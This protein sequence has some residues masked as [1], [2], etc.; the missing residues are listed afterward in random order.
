[1]TLQLTPVSERTKNPILEQA[2]CE[3]DFFFWS[4]KDI[5]TYF[6]N[7]RSRNYRIS[8]VFRS[9]LFHADKSHTGAPLTD[10]SRTG[11]ATKKV[12]DFIAGQL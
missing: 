11:A 4:P 10:T 3:T 7:C 1:M 9:Y 2:R 12:K 8:R 5:P 6:L